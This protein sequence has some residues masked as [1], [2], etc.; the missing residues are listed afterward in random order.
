M[1]ANQMKDVCRIKPSN[2]VVHGLHVTLKH[3]WPDDFSE[4]VGRILISGNV[5]D[6]DGSST[7]QFTHLEDLAI[8]VTRVLSRSV[9]VAQVICAFVV[10][11]DFNGVLDFQS[12][13]D[14]YVSDEE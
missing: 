3:L 5:V 8:D 9:P 1:A 11:E 2:S 4:D 6:S 13:K 14:A 12:H 7:P 10:G